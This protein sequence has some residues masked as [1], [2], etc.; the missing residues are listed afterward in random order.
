MRIAVVGPGAVGCLFAARLAQ[1]S[2][3]EVWL[4]DHDKKRAALIGERGL[5]LIEG[6]EKLSVNVSVSVHPEEMGLADLLILCVKSHDVA[7]AIDQIRVLASSENLLLALQNGIAHHRVLHEKYPGPWAIGVTAQGAAL[8]ESGVVRHGGDGDTTI[9]FIEA[10]NPMSNVLL[11]KAAKTFCDAGL[12]TLVGTKIEIQVWKKF[13]VNVGINALTVILDCPNG[14]LLKVP[15]GRRRLVKA[16]EEAACVARAKGIDVGA[17]PVS[18]TVNVCEATAINI[19]S[20]LQDVRRRQKTEIDAINGAL[21]REA[22]FHGIDVPE[23]E[24][25]IREVKEIESRYKTSAML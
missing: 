8:E 18:M 20:M 4:L 16:V 21:V 12:R 24:K 6:E 10:I 23:N 1:L 11:G 25:L 2:G 17:D 5:I 13:I 9:G 15:E 7:S 3:H 22:R 14:Q 19:S